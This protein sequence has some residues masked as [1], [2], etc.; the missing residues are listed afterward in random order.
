[1]VG[2]SVDSTIWLV[3][4]IGYELMLFASVGILLIGLDDL[5]LDAVW[6]GRGGRHWISKQYRPA[7]P[8]SGACPQVSTAANDSQRSLAI[9]IPAWR[10]SDVVPDMIVRTLALW[11]DQPFQIYVGCYPNDAATILAVSP[12]IAR[13]ARLRLV[14]AEDDGPTTKAGNLN[15]M[16]DALCRDEMAGQAEAAGIVLHDAED[17]VHR[18]E[19]AVFRRYLPDYAMVQIP[20]LPLPHPASRWISGHY[21]DEFAEAHGKELPLRSMLGAALP[22]AGVGCALS[23]E[24]L[25]HL[26]HMRGGKPFSPDSLT[27]DYEAGL[28]LSAAGLA[29]IFAA[30]VGRA[31]TVVLSQG[32]FPATVQAAEKQKARWTIGIA[33][34]GWDRLG[35]LT[36]GADVRRSLPDWCLNRWMLWRDRRAPLAAIIALAAYLAMGIWVVGLAG[37]ALLGWRLPV[38]GETGALL[39]SLNLILLV[40]RLVLRG[41]FTAKVYGWRQGLY[42]VPRSVVSNFIGIIAAKRA[43]ALYFTMVKQR[44]TIWE[45]TAHEF[46]RQ[47]DLGYGPK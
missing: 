13:D 42:A 45:K 34:A 44:R 39:L 12:I 35:W 21:M 6:L 10:E 23:R 7:D 37:H 22:S 29:T 17:Y 47:P 19:L 32:Y 18:D 5:L 27:E 15:A 36:P 8:T 1:M 14:V 9:F 24:A 43:F 33:M 4:A 3:L 2:L 46:S 30:E 26:A 41:Y 31:G 20:V 40:W 28:A 11:H 38:V 16:W 25:R